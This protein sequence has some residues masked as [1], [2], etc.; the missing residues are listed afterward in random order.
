MNSYEILKLLRELHSYERLGNRERET[1]RAVIQHIE[2]QDN[3]I[4]DLRE[5]ITNTDFSDED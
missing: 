4:T 2:G 5:D 3:D 1:I